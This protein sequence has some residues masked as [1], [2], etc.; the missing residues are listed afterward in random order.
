ML[1]RL[2]VTL[3]LVAGA[4]GISPA[5][6]ARLA[7]V[8]WSH[9]DAN[10]VTAFRIYLRQAG[11]SYGAPAWQGLP[12][13]SGGVYSVA[14]EVA[15]GSTVY[16]VGTAVNA[17]GE[18]AFSNELTLAPPAPVCGNGALEA[19][20]QCDDGNTASGD[21]CRA[22]CTV[23]RCGDARLDPGEQCDDGNTAGGDGCSAT[24]TVERIP[25]CG[26]G[27]RD[28]GEQCDDGNTASGD[29]CRAD[30]TVER[31]G[32]ARLDPGEQC[33]DGNTAGGDGCRADC[34]I[35]RC[36]D[37]RRDPGEQC[38]D[39]NANGGDGCRADCTLEVCG[40]GRRDPGEQCDDGNTAGGDGCRAD[41]TVERCGD[42]R[43]DPGEQCDDGNTASGD[44]CSA[45]CRAEAA[46]CGDGRLDAGEQCDDGNTASGDGCDAQCRIESASTLLPLRVNVGGPD[47]TDPSGQLWR[48]DAAFT[49]GGSRST[50]TA[51]IRNTTADPLYQSRRYGSDAEA[52]VTVQLPVGGAGLYRVRL[53]F[54]EVHEA[55]RRG[56]RVFDVL[57]EE[58]LWIRDIDVAGQVGTYRPATR[59]IS[60]YAA[61]DAISLRLVPKVGRPMLSGIEVHRLEETG[62]AAPAPT[63]CS[64]RNCR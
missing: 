11:Q 49:S 47:Y 64:R 52:P 50:T 27:I 4:V 2:V 62:A 45:T 10:G 32:D 41:C 13:P 53:H 40:D 42:A 31:C 54:A 1:R 63:I 17:E 5:A 20:E 6:E 48:D 35:E 60:V 30:C 15:D 23:E 28:A 61:D 24:C 51:A 36:G 25:A 14:L 7:T 44:G 19:P 43:L 9:P 22:D 29:G 55:G 58:A 16:A 46:A 3:A 8:R 18:S 33:D 37:A 26:D 34:T 38:D 56:E 59:E 39:G 21:G 12:A 57:V